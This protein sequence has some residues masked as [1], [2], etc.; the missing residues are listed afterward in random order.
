MA[1][2]ASGMPSATL[3]QKRRDI[4]RSSLSSAGSPAVGT[5]GSSAMPQM[6]HTPG[7]SRTISGC[8]GQVYFVPAIALGGAARTAGAPRRTKPLGAGARDWGD[9]CK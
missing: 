7:E 6:G 5:I 4:C 1:I 2:T 8:M 3:L 9:A